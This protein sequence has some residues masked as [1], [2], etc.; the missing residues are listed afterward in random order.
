MK[1]ELQDVRSGLRKVRRLAREF[2]ME[3]E[4]LEEYAAA[5]FD[6]V[7]IGMKGDTRFRAAQLRKLESA[8]QKGQR[9]KT[10]LL[11]DCQGSAEVS[12]IIQSERC[13]YL[14][15]FF[16]VSTSA[17]Q[18]CSRNRTMRRRNDAAR[19][20]PYSQLHVYLL[21][22]CHSAADVFYFASLH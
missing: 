3:T 19:S 12:L 17:S 10:N 2:E 6:D 20:R 14:T 13:M 15:Y 9:Y 7:E 21:R 8:L 5:F 1:L 18:M 4:A 16:S 22:E 11:V